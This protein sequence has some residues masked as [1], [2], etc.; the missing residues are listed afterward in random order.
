[1][2]FLRPFKSRIEII[3]FYAMFRNINQIIHIE[4]KIKILS[5]YICSSL[6]LL[7][8]HESLN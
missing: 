8:Y 5:M 7:L 1:M 3:H 2:T 6:V 4:I